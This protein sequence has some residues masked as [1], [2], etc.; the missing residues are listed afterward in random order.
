[1]SHITLVHKRKELLSNVSIAFAEGVPTCITGPTGSGKTLL[2]YI[3]AGVLQ[4]T[5]G[6]VERNIKLSHIQ[7]V[8]QQVRFKTELSQKTY[9]QNRYEENND[10]RTP[11][12]HQ[13]ISQLTANEVDAIQPL[14]QNFSLSHLMERQLSQLSNGESKRLQIVL[15]LAHRPAFIIL[16]NPYLGL[17]VAS[18]ALLQSHLELLHTMGVT[19]LLLTTGQVPIA[20]YVKQYFLQN[21]SLVS[22]LD[23]V[24]QQHSVEQAYTHIP[25]KPN[26]DFQ[27][28]V[29]MENVTIAYHHKTIL[30]HIY[31]QVVKGEKWVLR[32]ANGSGKSMLLSLI[33]GDNPKAYGQNIYLFDKKKGSGE[34]I[35]S[36]KNKIGYVSPELH[37]HFLKSPEH[38]VDILKDANGYIKLDD[39][40]QSPISC[41]E[42]VASGLNDEVGYCS[43]IH[44]VQEKSSIALLQLFRLQQY[45]HSPFYQL[46]LGQQRLVLLAR[47]LIRN[48]P[49][50]ILDEPCQGLD[51][52]MITLFKETINYLAANTQVTVIYVSH[53]NEDIPSCMH[54]LLELDKGQVV[55]NGNYNVND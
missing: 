33:N 51:E 13:Y 49:L 36:I 20:P 30:Q 45:A 38:I 44:E 12:L 32:G 28:A 34:S 47:A 50:L 1:M 43:P 41:L 42:V 10:I 35:W 6:I 19:Y 21:G 16:D 18:R 4:P 26:A 9:Y 31:W 53:Y 52:D 39:M 22:K 24:A 23:A 8:P 25:Y 7:I 40:Y 55:Y 37:V 46:S 2:M 54:K 5:E 27:Y 3:I 15:A 11:T 14:L 17:D 48:P 29:T